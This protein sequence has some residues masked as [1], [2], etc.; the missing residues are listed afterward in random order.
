MMRL[1]VR[2]G[3]FFDGL[4]ERADVGFEDVEREWSSEWRL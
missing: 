3:G 4:M 1:P 2:L